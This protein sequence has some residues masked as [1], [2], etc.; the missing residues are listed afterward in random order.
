MPD[1]PMVSYPITDILRRIDE[2]VDKLFDLLSRKADKAELDALSVK[3]HAHDEQLSALLTAQAS[4]AAQ[5]RDKLEWRKW[6]WPT[7]LAALGTAAMI[8]AA[9]H[10]VG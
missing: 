2:K 3:V 5:R 9:V 8:L 10:P 7:L 1:E 6:L 4:A